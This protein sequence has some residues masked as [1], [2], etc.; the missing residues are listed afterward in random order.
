MTVVS[1]RGCLGLEDEHR[2]GRLITGREGSPTAPRLRRQ[3][4]CLVGDHAV[5]DVSCT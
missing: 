4:P 2:Q 5:A 3:A 1:S